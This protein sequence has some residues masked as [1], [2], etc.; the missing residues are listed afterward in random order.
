MQNRQRC[1]TLGLCVGSLVSVVSAADI[2]ISPDRVTFT[3]AFARRQLVVSADGT[4]VTRQATYVSRSPDVVAVD[5]KGY[6]VPRA[7][8][9]AHIEVKLGD[10]VVVV[11]VEVQGLDKVRPVDFATEVEPLLSRFGCNSGGCHGKAS[12]QNGFKLSLFGFDTEFDYAALVKEARGRRVFASSPEKSL[13]LAKASGQVPH[14]GGKRIE[15]GSEPYRMLLSWV[16]AGAPASAPDVARVVRL[17]LLPRE[18]ILQPDQQQQLVV[19]A[20]YS[21]GSQRDVTRDAQYSS[22]LDVVAVV[23]DD[24]LVT[25]NA[26]T[27][28]AAIMARYMGQVSVCTILRPQGAPLAELAG[29]EP[30]NFLD[31]LAARKWMKLGLKPSPVCDDQTFLRR[32]T[33]DLCGRLPTVDETREFLA[34]PQAEKREQLIERLLNSPDYPA[35]FALKWG[36]ILRNSNLAGSEK[37]SYAFHNW[38]KEMISRNRPYDEFVRGIVAASGEWQDAPAINWFWQSRDDQLHQVTA[39]T[40]QVFLGLRL[41]CAKCHHHPYERF[42]QDDYYGLAGFFTRLGRKS[43]G[44]PPP[45]FSAPNVTIGQTHPVTGQQIEPKFIDGAVTKFGPEEDPRHALVDW[46]ARPENPFFAKAF[47]NRLWGH[48]FGLG[49]VHEVDDL[50]ETNPASNPELL[51]RLAKEF[52]AHKFDMRHMVR[53]M[54]TSRTYQ[55]SS[56][57]LSE[58]AGD[59]QNFARYYPRR[60]TAEVLL[61][62]VDQATGHKSQFGNMSSDSRAVDLP[63]ENFGSY[64]LDTFDRPRRVTACECERGTAATLSQVLLLANSDELENKLAAGDGRIDKAFKAQKSTPQMIEDLYLASFARYPT[65]TEIF[66]AEAHIAGSP[67]PRRGVEDV[68]WSLLNS[69]EFL[70]NH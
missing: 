6:A 41:Q 69:R 2:R 70:F 42:S 43:F 7:N 40:A 46:M 54:V 64:L 31:E 15:P 24:G 53:L 8:G 20:H 21:D 45:Y 58:N 10:Q 9:V 34:N 57:P 11:P 36:S 50:R 56:T 35:Y 18:Q 16:Q 47:V 4:D 62:A 60:F 1:L 38:I 17:E 48:L 55:L 32:V 14:G 39:D 44:E 61:D 37:A 49:L 5:A 27:G 30:L 22:N 67:D 52:I 68:L 65:P 19:I 59:H 3:D 12:G 33:V 66:A 26:P 29:F 13:L 28:E 51:D 23:A 63:H 25:A